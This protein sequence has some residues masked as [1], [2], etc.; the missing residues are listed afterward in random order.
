MVTSRLGL[1]VALGLNAAFFLAVVTGYVWL[2][3]FALVA[4]LL[5]SA[6][7]SRLKAEDCAASAPFLFC[8][9]WLA[10]ESVLF[11]LAVEATL[12]GLAVAGVIW[13]E[14]R[15]Y[16]RVK[17]KLQA[18]FDADL[19]RAGLTRADVRRASKQLAA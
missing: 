12:C 19:A 10:F 3:A 1:H 8:L 16:N 2:G 4:S 7:W 14:K 18:D 15:A 9:S 13:R 11:S 6:L 17:A 5:V